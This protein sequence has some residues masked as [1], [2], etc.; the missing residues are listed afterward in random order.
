MAQARDFQAQIQ[1][2][3]PVSGKPGFKID[4]GY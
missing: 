2:L 3:L 4:Y 1:L